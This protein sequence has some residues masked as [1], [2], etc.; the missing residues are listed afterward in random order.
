MPPILPQ[1]SSKPLERV[2]EES[3]AYLRTDEGQV[4]KFGM[5]NLDQ[6][7]CL[8]RALQQLFRQFPVAFQ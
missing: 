7:A 1:G 8:A 5:T 4:I 6:L 3:Y 2:P